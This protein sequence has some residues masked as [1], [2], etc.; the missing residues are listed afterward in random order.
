MYFRR[1]LFKKRTRKRKSRKQYDAEKV[2]TLKRTLIKAL[3][4]AANIRNPEDDDFEWVIVTVVGESSESG[5][6]V[7][8]DRRTRDCDHREIT[9]LKSSGD[10]VDAVIT[11]ESSTKPAYLMGHSSATVMTMRVNKGDIDEFHEGEINF[12]EFRQKVEIFTD[13]TGSGFC[14]RGLTQRGVN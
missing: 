4:H 7:D 3:R 12:D 6:L 9:R 1:D 10:K 5:E 14:S 13:P 2:E 11:L 8:E